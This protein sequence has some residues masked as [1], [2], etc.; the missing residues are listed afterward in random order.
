MTALASWCAGDDWLRDLPVDEA[1]PMLFRMGVE[2]NLFQRRLETGQ[3]F[4]SS[5]L[6]E[7]RRCFS[8]RTRKRA[9]SR[10]AL[11]FQSRTLDQRVFCQSHGGVQEMIPRPLRTIIA[12]LLAIMLFNSTTA[13]ACG[14]FMLEAVFVYTVH[15]AYPLGTIRR[16]PNRRSATNLRTLVSLRRLPASLRFTVHH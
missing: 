13:L 12:T 9:G 8:R 15:P 11:H 7:H 6:P 16:R 10:P 2:K 3:R 4:E 14:P 1:V 5:H